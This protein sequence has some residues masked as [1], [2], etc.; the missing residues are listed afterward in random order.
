MMDGKLFVS[1]EINKGSTFTVQIPIVQGDEEEVKKSKEAAKIP[2]IFAPTAQ[3]LIV[4]DNDFNLKVAYGL[5]KL[6]G[7]D[8][9]TVTSGKAALLAL[10][11]ADFDIIFMDHMMPEMDGI[12]ATAEIRKLGTKYIDMP[13]IALTAN[14]IRGAKE[15]FMASGF[16]DFMAKPIDSKELNEK[17]KEWLPPEKVDVAVEMV[18][19]EAED[20]K[21]ESKDAEIENIISAIAAIEEINIEIGLS[22]FS[23]I[24][25]MYAEAAEVFLKKLKENCDKMTRY[26]EEEDTYNF[27]IEIHAMKSV[28]STLGAMRLSETALRMENS[29]KNG[30][31]DYCV[32]LFLGFKEKL[33]TLH[34]RLSKVMPAADEETHKEA[35]SPAILGEYIEKALKATDEFDSDS[36]IAAIKELL[37]YDFGEEDNHLLVAIL[38]TFENFDFDSAA[39]YLRKI[40]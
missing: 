20:S 37:K 1:S 32:R 24:K 28:L 9:V 35:G 11:G 18:T 12:E 38:G 13:I 17:L 8:S 34:E 14:A 10:K 31:L 33:M 19:A 3:V 39:E 2:P 7:I 27:A 16:H 25:Y 36:G 4:D 22:R 6:H 26:L 29:A 23:G 5:L 21:E 15:M 40:K 30:D